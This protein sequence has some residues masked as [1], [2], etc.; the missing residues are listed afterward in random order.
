MRTVFFIAFLQSL[1]LATS[2]H[3]ADEAT[4]RQ[5]LERAAG[6]LRSISTNGGYVGIYSLDLKKRYG[7]AVYE[8]AGATQ[9]WVQPPGTPSVGEVFLRA[10]RVTGKKEY[11]DLSRDA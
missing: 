2:S 8:K 7:E 6:C 5:A 9:I 11:L 1:I 3:G 4:A 10:H